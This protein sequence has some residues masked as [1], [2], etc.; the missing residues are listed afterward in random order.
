L[1]RWIRA[2]LTAASASAVV[3]GTSSVAVGAEPTWSQQAPMPTP[4]NVVV[5]VGSNSAA[6]VIGGQGCKDISGSV[7]YPLDTVEVFSPSKNT[8]RSVASMPTPRMQAAATLGKDSKI[9]VA[10]GT[11]A[12]G[13]VRALEVYSPASDSWRSLAPLP[14][15]RAESELATSKDG[16]IFAIGGDGSMAD[17]DVSTT[18]PPI[19]G[20]LVLRYRLLAEVMLSSPHPTV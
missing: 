14:S 10:G 11:G 19:G 1:N 8:W 5:A 15:A 12:G 2:L 9:Y 18:P 17:V 16:K 3:L 13:F 6:Y 4:R 20:H 7:C